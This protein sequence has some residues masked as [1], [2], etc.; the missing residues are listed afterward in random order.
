MQTVYVDPAVV[1]AI[2]ND[3]R[4][5]ARRHVGTGSGPRLSI[6]ARMGWVRRAGDSEESLPNT[7]PAA[8]RVPS[9]THGVSPS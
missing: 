4:A 6:I 7:R 9:L 3:Y 2:Q 1:G 8:G 5:R